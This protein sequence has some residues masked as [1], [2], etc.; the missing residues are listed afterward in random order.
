MTKK[1]FKKLMRALMT[2]AYLLGETMNISYVYKNIRDY[3]ASALHYFTSYK[4]LYKE[5]QKF[6]KG[7]NG[8]DEEKV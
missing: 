4:R 8:F 5:Y 7:D 3:N 1:R 2:E 6:W